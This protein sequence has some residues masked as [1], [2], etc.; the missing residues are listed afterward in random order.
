[1][2]FYDLICAFCTICFAP[3]RFRFRGGPSCLPLYKKSYEITNYSNSKIFSWERF[4]RPYFT[5]KPKTFL[6]NISEGKCQYSSGFK[7]YCETA[8]ALLLF[9]RQMRYSRYQWSAIS[10]KKLTSLTYTQKESIRATPKWHFK[11]LRIRTALCKICQ[12][13]VRFIFSHK[14]KRKIQQHEDRF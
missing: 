8:D 13:H 5:H 9:S 12:E 1:M 11:E 7:D 10:L 14:I 4:N 6:L 3:L 2:Y